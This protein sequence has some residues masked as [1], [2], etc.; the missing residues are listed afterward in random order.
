MFNRNAA[1]DKALIMQ[2]EWQRLLRFACKALSIST[3][4]AEDAWFDP[5]IDGPIEIYTRHYK[6]HNSPPPGNKFKKH[7]AFPTSDE[8]TIRAVLRNSLKISTFNKILSAGGR[9]AGLTVASFG[10]YGRFEVISV[11]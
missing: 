8:L 6:D 10:E 3:R 11:Q 7:E 4:L 2:K 1:G 5:V 9:Y